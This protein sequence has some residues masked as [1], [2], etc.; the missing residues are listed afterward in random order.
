MSTDNKPI[1]SRLRAYMQQHQQQALKEITEDL[2]IQPDA[3]RQMLDYLIHRGQVSKLPEGTLCSGC[4]Q[5]QPQTIEIY[6]W[7][8]R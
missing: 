4:T 2:A 6:R 3:A 1:L 5:C 8:N 7:V